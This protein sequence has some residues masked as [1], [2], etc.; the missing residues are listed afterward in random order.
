M[1]EQEIPK[2]KTRT[3]ERA[4]CC[5]Q[6]LVNSFD[7]FEKTGALQ[8]IKFKKKITKKCTLMQLVNMY[9]TL[10]FLTK[11]LTLVFFPLSF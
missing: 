3:P 7:Y 6:L 1:D 11:I 10:L 9:H 8:K 2:D 5:N 4:L